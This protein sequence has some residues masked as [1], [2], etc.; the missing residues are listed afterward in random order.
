MILVSFIACAWI[1][2]KELRA[3][4]FITMIFS[5]TATVL[6]NPLYPIYFN[7]QTQYIMYLILAIGFLASAIFDLLKPQ[8]NHEI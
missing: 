5:L 2:Y 1:T 8:P 7:V 4:N 3:N 6:F